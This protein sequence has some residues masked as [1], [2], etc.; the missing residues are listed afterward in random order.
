MAR[1]D[2]S[3]QTIATTAFG[4]VPV[5][6]A[7]RFSRLDVQ[8]RAAPS[9]AATAF[10]LS[11]LAPRTGDQP[12]QP[13]GTAAGVDGHGHGSR[14]PWTQGLPQPISLTWGDV[15][16]LDVELHNSGPEPLLFSPGQLRLR[17]VPADTTI[18]PLTVNGARS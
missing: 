1:S 9:L 15:V 4:T 7:G 10:L 2:Q 17:L 18:T 13:A 5:L 16:V 6:R 12:L 14:Q 11:G 3:A 8:G